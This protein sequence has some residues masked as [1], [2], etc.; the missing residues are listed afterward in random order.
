MLLIN[1]AISIETFDARKYHIAPFQRDKCYTIMEQAGFAFVRA[2][3]LICLRSSC[4]RIR[5]SD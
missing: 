3:V 4:G 1:N 2:G 5:F